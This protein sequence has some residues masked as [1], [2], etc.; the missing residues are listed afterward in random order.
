M[1]LAFHTFPLLVSSI[2]FFLT[3]ILSHVHPT[4][5]V[6]SFVKYIK[7][8]SDDFINREGILPKFNG[9]QD[10]CGAF[11]ESIKSKGMLINYIKNQEE[12]YKKVSFLEEYKGLLK[13]FEID[14]DEN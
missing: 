8:A 1:N 2:H 5:T 11:S 7:L 3:H 14:F 9:W 4:I 13:E 6:S 10:G 12:H